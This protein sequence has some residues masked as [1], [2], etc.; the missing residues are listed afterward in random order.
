MTR[1]HLQPAKLLDKRDFQFP[2]MVPKFLSQDFLYGVY[3]PS[4]V[5]VFGVAVA[6]YDYLPYALAVPA[7][8][9]GVQYAI[10]IVTGRWK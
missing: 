2:T 8:L 5:A 10:G 4:A 9:V 3:V 1:L 6:A 7:L